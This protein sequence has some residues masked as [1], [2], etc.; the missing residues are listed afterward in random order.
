[1]LGG[2]LSFVP[3]VGGLSVLTLS[4]GI[5]IVQGWPSLE[6][7]LLAL[8]VVGSGQFLEGYIL[9]PMLVGE[10]IGLHPVWLMFA[11]LAFGRL[12]G[13]AGLIVAVPAAAAIGV[14]ARHLIA[15]YL[16]SPLYRGRSAAGGP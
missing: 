1:M 2:L 3:Y 12:F 4:L 14:I 7:L 10:S 11:L 5:A 16:T 6:L 13:F 15:V 8:G 9:S